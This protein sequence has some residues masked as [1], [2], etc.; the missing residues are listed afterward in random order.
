MDFND[1]KSIIESFESFLPKVKIWIDNLLLQYSSES[2]RVI[3]LRFPRLPQYFSKEILESAKVV[4]IDWPPRISLSSMGLT[5][6]KDFE[7]MAVD[8]ITYYDTFFV[9]FSLR[10]VEYLHFHELVHVAQWRYLGPDKFLLL[11]GLE[12]LKNNYANN[13]LETTAYQLHLRFQNTTDPFD[14]E[15]I[16]HQ[17]LEKRISQLF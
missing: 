9:R 13:M 3:D 5:Q 14:V 11:Y 16:V 15:S 8:G 17:E 4:Y 2:K 10:S 7:T 6:F 1:D 12:L